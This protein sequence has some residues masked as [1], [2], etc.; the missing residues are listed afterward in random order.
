MQSF[1]C[2][3]VPWILNNR[4]YVEYKMSVLISPSTKSLISSISN[5]CN[6]VTTIVCSFTFTQPDS[7]YI[8]YT[9]ASVLRSTTLSTP[10]GHWLTCAW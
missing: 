8:R 4:P 7:H 6:P 1:W 3:N 9:A 5:D 2:Q 10:E